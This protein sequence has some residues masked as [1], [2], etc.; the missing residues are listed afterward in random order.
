MT[1]PLQVVEWRAKLLCHPPHFEHVP[2]AR[3][4][5]VPPGRAFAARGLQ[6]L[7]DL[8]RQWDELKISVRI[9]HLPPIISIVLD[10]P[11]TK[12]GCFRIRSAFGFGRT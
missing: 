12:A 3:G 11:K 2:G 9:C 1:L 7:K 10:W 6:V 5:E 8:S 4:I